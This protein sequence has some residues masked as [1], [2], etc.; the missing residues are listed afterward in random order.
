MGRPDD[1]VQ[2]EGRVDREADLHRLVELISRRHDNQDVHVAVRV[3]GAVRVRAE[4][5]DLVWPEPLRYVAGELADQVHGNIGT[6]VEALAVFERDESGIARHA[7]ILP[8]L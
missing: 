5:D 3:R 4:Q 8:Q 1:D 6:V 7:A 2:W